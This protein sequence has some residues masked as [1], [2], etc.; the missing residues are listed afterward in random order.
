MYRRRRTAA[1]GFTLIELMI[2]VGIVAVLAG[3][4]YPVYNDSIR[5]GKRGQAKAALVELAQRAE[6][7]R[8]VQGSYAGFWTTVDTAHRVSPRDGAKAYDLT[9]TPNDAN[10]EFTLAA[11]PY[12]SQTGDTRCMTLTLT[13][14]GEKDVGGGATGTAADCW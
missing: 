7:H 3:I 6:R 2:T 12:G 10:T 8:T 5:K 13:Q 4:A 1:R 11:A 9:F 14:A